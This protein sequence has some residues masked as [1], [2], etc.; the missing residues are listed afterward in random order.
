MRSPLN[1]WSMCRLE[2]TGSNSNI[3]LN[4]SLVFFQKILTRIS[5]RSVLFELRAA[6]TSTESEREKFRPRIGCCSYRAG[7]LLPHESLQKRFG[8]SFV[9][10]VSSL[11]YLK[12]MLLK[13]L[14][15]NGGLVGLDPALPNEIF[16]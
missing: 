15:K 3:F 4:T 13:L 6:L 7:L 10:R 11:T 1:F 9:I 14:P 5:F 8:F 12:D 16:L 2:T